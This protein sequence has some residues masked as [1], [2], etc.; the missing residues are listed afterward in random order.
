MLLA[1]TKVECDRLVCMDLVSLIII[2]VHLELPSRIPTYVT[3][4]YI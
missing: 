2:L 1:R 3:V 4:L